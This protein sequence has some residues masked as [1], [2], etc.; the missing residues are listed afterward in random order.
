MKLLREA[1]DKDRFDVP[2][3]SEGF[4]GKTWAD[5]KEYDDENRCIKA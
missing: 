3:K 5:I 2:F 4:M 1:M